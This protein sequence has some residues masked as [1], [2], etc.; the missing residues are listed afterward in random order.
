MAEIVRLHDW[1][2]VF[3]HLS[4]HPSQVC[5]L[6]G[7]AFWVRDSAPLGLPRGALGYV[8]AVFTL[9]G[10]WWVDVY[11]VPLDAQGY[12]DFG[13]RRT[14]RRKIDL[15]TFFRAT[16]PVGPRAREVSP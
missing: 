7:K 4:A 5:T 12:P 14:L 13:R 10:R 8:D 1:P 6:V 9:K 2:G 15:S 3:G 16:G 11:A